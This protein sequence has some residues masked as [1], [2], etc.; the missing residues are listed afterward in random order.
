[1][2]VETFDADVEVITLA[3]AFG[4]LMWRMKN[5]GTVP[6]RI[7][8]LSEEARACYKDLALNLL[9]QVKRDEQ[10]AKRAREAGNPRA[11]FCGD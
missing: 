4:M 7:L 10:A 2:T 3:D 1:M 11:F 5:P 9:Q 6:P 8:C